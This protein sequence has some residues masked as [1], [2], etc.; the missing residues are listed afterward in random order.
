MK[1]EHDKKDIE[2]KKHLDALAKKISETKIQFDLKKGKDGSIFGSI[3]KESVLKALREHKLISAE[4]IEMTLDH[5]IKR[6]GEYTIA[7]DLKKGATA[8]LKI[9]VT[10][11]GK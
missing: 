3:N 8:S 10:D 7:I 5:P 9:V 6:P 2:L 11:E 4:R 1:A